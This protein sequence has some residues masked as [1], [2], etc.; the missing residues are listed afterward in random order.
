MPELVSGSTNLPTT[1]IA[2]K[3]ADEMKRANGAARRQRAA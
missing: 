3:I 2:E 1:M